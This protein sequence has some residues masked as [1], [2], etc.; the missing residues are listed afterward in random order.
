MAVT[1]LTCSAKRKY[2]GMRC[3]SLAVWAMKA[4]GESHWH[5]ACYLHP[6]QVLKRLGATGKRVEVGVAT[7]V[8]AEEHRLRNGRYESISRLPYGS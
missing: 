3:H 5:G 6:H 4:D 1:T 2:A 7:E 8:M